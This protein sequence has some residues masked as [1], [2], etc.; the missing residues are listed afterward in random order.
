MRRESVSGRSRILRPEERFR[1]LA[2]RFLD[3]PEVTS[4]TGFGSAPGL[5]VRGKIFA[6]LVHDRLVVKLPRARVDELVS[7]G[8]GERFDPGHG[9]IMK[10]WVAI[11]AQSAADW[12]ELSTDAI[13]F[14]GRRSRG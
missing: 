4:G 12:I 8:D 10:E 11:P 2:A 5:R 14:V 7:S 3:D 6:M 9:R 13:A 1:R